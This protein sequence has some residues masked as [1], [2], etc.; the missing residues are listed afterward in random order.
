MPIDRDVLEAVREM[1]EP[2]L[3][4]LLILARARL[5]QRGVLSATQDD[6]DRLARIIDLHKTHRPLL[7]S[8]RVVRYDHADPAAMANAVIAHDQ[9][10][11]LVSFAQIATSDSLATGALRVT[12]LDSDR[13]YDV[14][15]VDIEPDRVWGKA[16]RQPKWIDSDLQ[17]TGAQLAAGLQMPILDP[18]SAVLMH[19]VAADA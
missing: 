16:F 10:E 17:L 12:G 6:R 3:R 8:G 2:E 5:E 9:S 13:V 19:L 4:R 14:R 18:E 1:D 7:H 11:A 15:L